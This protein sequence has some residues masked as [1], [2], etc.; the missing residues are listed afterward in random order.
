M[1]PQ[2]LEDRVREQ[3]EVIRRMAADI[4]FMKSQIKGKGVATKE[5]RKGNTHS[6]HSG[7]CDRQVTPSQ[8]ESRILRAGDTQAKNSRTR[9]SRP[10]RM[11]TERA[12]RRED[13]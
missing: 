4:E 3:D 8:T 9:Y 7:D 6:C 11:R 2:V 12:Q 5:G 13:T 10:E 1:D